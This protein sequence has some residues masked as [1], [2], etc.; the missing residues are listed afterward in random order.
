ML[1]NYVIQ[2]TFCWIHGGNKGWAPIL[3][4][5]TSRRRRP[6]DKLIHGEHIQVENQDVVLKGL[7]LA[8]ITCVALGKL[9][10][11]NILGGESNILGEGRGIWVNNQ[12]KY[13]ESLN[14]SILVQVKLG[15][16]SRPAS[17]TTPTEHGNR[18]A[19]I[20]SLCE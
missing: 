15:K 8:L 2:E 7:D 9:L 5:C 18:H 6:I 16:F 10:T 13:S 19:F 4:K 20:L 11:L 17:T 1:Y 14:S 12:I 3:K